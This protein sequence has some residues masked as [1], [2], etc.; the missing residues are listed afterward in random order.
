MP[1]PTTVAQPLRLPKPLSLARIEKALLWGVSAGAVVSL[2]SMP[3]AVKVLT[4]AYGHALAVRYATD[5]FPPAVTVTI[6]SIAFAFVVME[7]RRK[8]A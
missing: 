4:G 6:L 2:A 5:Y 1:Q 7:A 8:R 3:L